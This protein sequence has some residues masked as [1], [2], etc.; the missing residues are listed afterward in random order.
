MLIA[1]KSEKISVSPT[2]NLKFD[3]KA[4]LLV[5]DF[6]QRMLFQW[7]NFFFVVDQHWCTATFFQNWLA[8]ITKIIIIMLAKRTGKLSELSIEITFLR[9]PHI[10]KATSEAW[11]KP[12]ASF[13]KQDPCWEMDVMANANFALSG[14][15]KDQLR[16]V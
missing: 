8:Q 15:T 12:H 10:V 5:V 1:L 14:K 6:H 16:L 3:W 4:A 9:L 13:I 7:K 11:L 2:Q